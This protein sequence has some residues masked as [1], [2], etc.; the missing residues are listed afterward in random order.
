MC[1]T[2][3]TPPPWGPTYYLN[4]LMNKI[5][6][7]RASLNI[8]NTPLSFSS[9]KTWAQFYKN[10]QA[11]SSINLMQVGAKSFLRLT[12]YQDLYVGVIV[13]IFCGPIFSVRV[14]EYTNVIVFFPQK[15]LKIFLTCPSNFRLIR[16]INPIM[17][18]RRATRKE[19]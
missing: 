17:K 6:Q 3:L 2:L 16:P 10:F 13:M 12:N 4:D 7:K 5:R 15:S 19:F 18:K 8:L 14:F 11:P 9:Y 1:D